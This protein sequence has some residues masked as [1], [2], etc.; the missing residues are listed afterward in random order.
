ML[1]AVARETHSGLVLLVGDRAYKIKKPIRT[2][3]LDFSTPQRRRAALRREL[4]LNRRLGPHAYLGIGRFTDPTDDAPPSEP[5]LLMRR[6]PDDRRLSGL[7]RAGVD[8]R[9]DLR[10]VART[11]V[12]FHTRAERSAAIDADGTPAA[13]AARWTA[14]LAE[15]D[16]ALPVE[17]VH[18]VADLVD[19]FLAGRGPLLDDRVARGRIVDGHGDLLADDVF[20]VPEGPQLLDCLD[21]DDHLRHVDV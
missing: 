8:V 17:Q 3:Y 7:V 15:L 19:R 20:C 16:R 6:M 4:E 12:A 10:A 2:A 21:F 14:N 18:E 11:L 13:L 1:R 5:V 9:A